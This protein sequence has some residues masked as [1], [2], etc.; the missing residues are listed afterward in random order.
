MGISK[1]RPP[2]GLEAETQRVVNDIYRVL[3]DVINAVNSGDVV[4]EKKEHKGKSGDV[5]VIKNPENGDAHI[6]IR[7]EDGWYRSDGS[8]ASGFS[9]KE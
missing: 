4:E 1:A 5:R 7:T 8:S 2:K 6:E 3:N 9:I